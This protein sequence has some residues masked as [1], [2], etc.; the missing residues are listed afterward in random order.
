MR[1]KLALALAIGLFACGGKK[2]DPPAAGTGSAPKAAEPDKPVTCPPG[3]ALG[4]D[5]ACTAVITQAKVDAVGQQVSRLDELVKLLDTVDTVAAPVA[6]L[7]RL[8]QLDA[9]KAAALADSRLRTVDETVAK[10]GE[11]VKALRAFKGEVSQLSAN[12]GNLR[13]ELDRL[14]KSNGPTPK[15]AELR[16]TITSK[17]KA[18]LEPFGGTIA[19]VIRSAVVPLD[20]KLTEANAYIVAGCD[21]VRAVEAAR[22]VCKDVGD[23]FAKSLA[24][25]KDYKAKPAQLFESISTDLTKQ[26]DQLIDAETKKLLDAA[27]AKV[28][29]ALRLPA[30]DGSNSAAKP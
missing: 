12:L 17:V 11:A 20:E 14:L 23:V 7:D 19:E 22:E 1:H 28:N 25:L 27:Q 2:D 21:I 3:S 8:R 6:V 24:A 13:G 26:L 9:W 15:L 4:A 10:G 18:A 5:G 29:S 30:G 16:T